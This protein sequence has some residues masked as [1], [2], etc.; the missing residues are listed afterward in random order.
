MSEHPATEYFAIRA[1]AE[2]RRAEAA[3]DPRAAAIHADLAARYEA[4]A[5]D[6]SLELP[7]AEL[8]EDP[9]LPSLE[10]SMLKAPALEPQILCNATA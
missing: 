7:G 2:R 4:L 8:P 1:I 5:S 3:A 6:P 10:P 9:E